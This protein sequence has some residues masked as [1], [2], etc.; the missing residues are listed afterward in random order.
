L[1]EGPWPG[2][3]YVDAAKREATR[4]VPRVL[5]YASKRAPIVSQ[6]PFPQNVIE[7]SPPSGDATS[8]PAEQPGVEPGSLPAD[9]ALPLPPQ[10]K[11]P[12]KGV[13][14][15][16]QPEAI[17][18]SATEVV[19]DKR[20]HAIGAGRG[21]IVKPVVPSIALQ[22][23]ATTHD[24]AQGSTEPAAPRRLPPTSGGK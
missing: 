14:R 18:V 10:L 19:S 7:G 24:T 23:G 21:D 22:L 13:S 12:G 15:L 5:N 17:Q 3:A 16:S 4:G 11:G 9:E 6:G 2:E 8:Q 20:H 1:A